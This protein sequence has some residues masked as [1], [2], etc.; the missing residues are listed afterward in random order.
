MKECKTADFI[1]SVQDMCICQ[2][3]I[4]LLHKKDELFVYDI[5]KKHITFLGQI[6]GNDN[7]LYMKIHVFDPSTLLFVP[8]GLG[9]IVEYRIEEGSFHIFL[10]YIPDKNINYMPWKDMFRYKDRIYFL[11]LDSEAGILSTRVTTGEFG[12]ENEWKREFHNRFGC[13]AL[14]YFNTNACRTGRFFW[15]PLNIKNMIMQYDMETGRSFFY[16]VGT[17]DIYYATICHDGQF[18]W[19]S[20]DVPVIVRWDAAVNETKVYRDFPAGFEKR[21]FEDME[22]NDRDSFFLSSLKW[23]NRIYFSPLRANMIIA[24]DLER[25]EFIEIKKVENNV[26]W[27]SLYILDENYLYFQEQSPLC[28]HEYCIS[29]EGGLQEGILRGKK[30]C[31][32]RT[33]FLNKRI[34]MESYP[35]MLE[36][37]IESFEKQEDENGLQKD[38]NYLKKW[39]NLL[40]NF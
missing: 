26:C 34:M 10:R 35:S 9:N 8:Y 38:N 31:S 29:Y 37:C 30:I 13:E 25:E 19:L 12:I 17:E 39:Q 24:L 18:F 23:H 22:K 16:R 27:F 20:G 7:A 32:E 21:F 5:L 6:E 1:L 36:G 14:L 3:K 2:E 28:L 33:A 15:V 4:Y 11:G 40:K